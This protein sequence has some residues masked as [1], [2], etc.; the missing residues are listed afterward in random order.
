MPIG[1][2]RT[3][4]KLRLGGGGEINYVRQLIRPR[5]FRVELRKR[6]CA[7]GILDV[8]GSLIRGRACATLAAIYFFSPG[9]KPSRA[10]RGRNI[11]RDVTLLRL[12]RN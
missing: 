7:R 4:G 6:D 1:E 5:G 11:Y 8:R 12:F 9:L 3:A 2:E 10:I